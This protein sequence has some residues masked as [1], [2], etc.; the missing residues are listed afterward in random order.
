MFVPVTLGQ[1]PE[2]ELSGLQVH[3]IIMRS[4]DQV[5][6]QSALRSVCR[7]KRPKFRHTNVMQVGNANDSVDAADGD[8][9]DRSDDSS[10]ILEVVRHM[11]VIVEN[12]FLHIRVPK[13]CSEASRAT[14]SAPAGSG[15][16]PINPRRW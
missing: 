5:R 3:H 12:T 9:L 2:Q 16:E 10:E 7:K 6:L 13:D 11:G 14:Q 8:I 4:S 1:L 15:K